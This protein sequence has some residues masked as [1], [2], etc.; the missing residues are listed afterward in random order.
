MTYW[1][2]MKEFFG[3]GGTVVEETA[4][5]DH[6][7]PP[8]P[9]RA[10]PDLQVVQPITAKQPQ[11]SLKK[12][13]ACKAKTNPKNYYRRGGRYYSAEDDSLIE[14]LVLL[15]V[16]SELFSDNDI[17]QYNDGE[18]PSREVTEDLLDVDVSSTPVVEAVPEPS[19]SAP[20]P[21]PTRYDSGSSY[22]SGSSDSGSSYDSGS[23]DS[24]GGSDD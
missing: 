12:A 2:N 17:A 3:L 5:H 16:L 6:F 14:D 13:Q 11:I 22:S 10:V 9:P 8:R 1:Q 20:D 15:Y 19:Y 4:G 21:E 18:F 7:P 24:G 23:S